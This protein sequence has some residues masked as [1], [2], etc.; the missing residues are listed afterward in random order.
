MGSYDG[1]ESCERVGSFLLHQITQKHGENFGLYRDD[2]F[3]VI[4][5][6]PHTIEIIKKD[7]CSR[8][9]TIMVKNYHRSQQE[10]SRFFRRHPKSVYPKVS[11]VH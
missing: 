8:S 5:A 10:N 3:G 9:S 6:T 1:A 4:K 7:I 11:A 2:G